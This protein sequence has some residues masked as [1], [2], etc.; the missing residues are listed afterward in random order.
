[1]KPIVQTHTAAQRRLVKTDKTEHFTT[2]LAAGSQ[3]Y[4][5]FN[6][7]TFYNSVGD[8][9]TELKTHAS[10]FLRYPVTLGTTLQ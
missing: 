10:L 4:R 9:T 3:S 5:H 1:M 6:N 8:R 2:A 7:R